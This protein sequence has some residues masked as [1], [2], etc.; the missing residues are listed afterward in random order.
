MIRYRNR[1]ILWVAGYVICCMTSLQA[2][3]DPLLEETVTNY[4]EMSYTDERVRLK[5]SISMED[6]KH[7]E[8]ITVKADGEPTPFQLVKKETDKGETNRIRVWVAPTLKPGESRTYTVSRGGSPREKFGSPVRVEENEDEHTIVLD[9]GKVTLKLPAHATT[10][11]RGPILSINGRGK[12]RW[13]TSALQSSFESHVVTDGPLFAT[14]TIRYEFDKKVGPNKETKAFSEITVTLPANRPYAII[15]E[16]HQMERE[17]AWTFVASDQWRPETGLMR[18]WWKAQ[19]DEPDEAVESFPLKPGYTRLGK[20]VIHLQPRWT[21]SFDEGWFFGATDGSKLI[22]ALPLRA[23]KWFWPHNNLISARVDDSGSYAAFRC[24]TFRGERFWLLTAGKEDIADRAMEIARRAGFAPLNKLH[25][26]YVLA[27]KGVENETIEVRNFFGNN[28]NPTGGMRSLGDN[29]IEKAKSGETI[30]SR[31][32][33]YDVQAWLDPDWYGNYR[34]HWS[35]INPNFYTDFIKPAIGW[36]AMLREHPEFA[37]FRERVEDAVRADVTHSITLPGGAGQE[38]P[39]YVGYAMKSWRE[40]APVCREY[41]G[42]DPA[43]WRRFRAGPSF[44]VRVSQPVKNGNARKFHPGG[45]THPG[46][47]DPVKYARTFGVDEEVGNLSTEELPGF[48]V[49]FRDEPGTPNETYLA[50]KSGPNR[51]HYHGDQLSFHYNARGS[52]L[53]VDHQVSYSPRAGQEHTHNRVSFSTEEFPY[54]NMD[55]HERVIAFKPGKHVDMVIGQVESSRLR[56]VMKYPPEEWDNVE[57]VTRFKKNLIYRRTIVQIKHDDRPNYFVVRDQYWGPELTATYNLHVLG[58]RLERNGRNIDFS[59]LRLFVAKPDTFSFSSFPSTLDTW[60]DENHKSE[61]TQGARISTKGETIEFITVL[62]PGEFIPSMKSLP[63][64]VKLGNET[65]TFTGGLPSGKN[66]RT[67]VRVE[68]G[69]ELLAELNGD[70]I[71]MNRSQGKVG[72]FVPDVGY[73][74]GPIPRWLIKQRAH[75]EDF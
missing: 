28:T 2:F 74:F 60:M 13:E 34:N 69:G 32:R 18:R 20:T 24:P 39:G 44:L 5:G 19:F 17:D 61:E 21:Q 48:G 22:G 46:Q 58:D 27:W 70:E 49:V 43:S 52:R 40:I 42:F 72:L 50:F 51:G 1:L 30:K 71:D 33:L 47:P 64:G 37:R 67:H 59:R 6:G 65:I 36:A 29:A 53:A 68:R 15:E 16:S 12:S 4:T 63:N 62:Y 25:H 73:P 11:D 41:L 54:A 75:S 14:A 38:C 23:G 10:A 56:K 8:N 55:G 9:N 31:Q 66:D 35:P 45:D 26:K 57:P 3:C 7:S